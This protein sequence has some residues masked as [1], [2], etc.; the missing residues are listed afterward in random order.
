[1]GFKINKAEIEFAGKKRI[2]LADDVEDMGFVGTGAFM[3]AHGN[4]KLESYWF[5]PIRLDQE[6]TPDI[7]VPQEIVTP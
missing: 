4:G 1:M 2:Y 3:V 7:E 6:E 5:C